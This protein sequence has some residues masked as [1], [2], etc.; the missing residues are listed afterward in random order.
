MRE[1]RRLTR[2]LLAAT[3]ACSAALA[4]C[5]GGPGGPQAEAGPSALVDVIEDGFA[6]AGPDD[7]A[8]DAGDTI[9]PAT[10]G[11]PP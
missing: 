7:D 11:G 8:G 5:N 10:D 2:A 6:D 4:G 3:I 1:L 9:P